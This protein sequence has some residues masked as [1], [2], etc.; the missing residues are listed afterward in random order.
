MN[1]GLEH[2]HPYPFERLAKLKE[3]L[4]PPADLKHIA[5]SIGEP[6]HP[7]PAFVLEELVRRQG[8]YSQ[9]PATK[10]IPQLRE[11]I[12]DWIVRRFN[13]ARNLVDPER[14]V[15]PV[16]GTREALFAFAQC[17]IDGTAGQ[18]V[19]MPN[20][21]YQIYEGA[22]WLAGAKPVYLNCLPQN[23][24]LPDFAAAPDHVW[25]DCRLLYLC[26]PG[27]P[28]GA[29]MS[30][31]QLRGL[32][33]LSDR[34]GF[35]IAGDECYSE[36]YPE[37]GRTPVGLLEACAALGRDDFKNCVVFHS[38]SKRSNLPGLRSGFVA[39]DTE[40]LAQFLRYRTYHGCAMPVPVQYASIAAWNDEEHVRANRDLYREKFAAVLPILRE[41]LTV[42]EPAA[43]FYLWPEVPG[44]GEGF[45]KALFRD[46]HVTVLPGAYLARTADGVN[47]GSNRVRITLV[48][49][50]DECRE[51]AERIV[52]MIRG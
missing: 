36:I 10:G 13:V 21:F 26:S 35:I 1:P 50:V 11:A 30:L 17:V 4:R 47:P 38:L 32:L 3:G 23:G 49:S 52:R 7:A 28:T 2:L 33:E 27:N 34:F 37:E 14:H 16:N 25:R 44:D 29:V 40:L 51:A 41:A 9:Y 19:A 24:Y 8:A 12:A 48:A 6:Q 46:F 22:A 43:G 42:D 39:G 15:L 5:L 31:D 20:P 45:A 18:T